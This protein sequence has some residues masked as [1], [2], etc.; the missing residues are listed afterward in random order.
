M[1]EQRQQVD[2]F[3]CV[4]LIVSECV[5][6]FLLVLFPQQLAVR[7][8]VFLFVSPIKRRM[9]PGT[10]IAD[11]TR[12]LKVKFTETVKSLPYSTKFDTLEGTRRIFSS[13]S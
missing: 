7:G 8:N 13:Y 4:R 12:F 2:F 3:V 1:N 9:W 6:L 5:L 11:G 10:D